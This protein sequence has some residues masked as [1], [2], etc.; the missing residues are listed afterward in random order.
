[1]AIQKART[2]LGSALDFL[3]T[4]RVPATYFAASVLLVIIGAYLTRHSDGTPSTKWMSIYRVEDI[5]NVREALEFYSNLRVPIPIPTSLLEIVSHLVS[6]NTL[7]VGRSVYRVSIVIA[8]WLALMMC[9]PSLSR[10]AVVF[11]VSVLFL[12][13]TTIIHP[14]NP[15]VYD[16]IF[17]C[18]VLLSLLFLKAANRA[19]GVSAGST[20]AA[21][22]AG[23]FLSLAELTRPFFIF[24]LPIVILVALVRLRELSRRH[25]LVFLAPII[26]LSGTWHLYQFTRYGQLTWSNHSGFNLSRAWPMVEP[27]DLIP[28]VSP[29]IELGRWPNLNTAEHAEN[30]RRWQAALVQYVIENPIYSADHVMRKFTDFAGAPTG[31]WAHQPVHPALD[32]YRPTVLF[33][34]T[35]VGVGSVLLVLSFAGYRGKATKLLGAPENA[36][37][38]MTFLSVLILPVS[39]MGEEARLLIS[40]LP[41]LA[42]MQPARHTLAQPGRDPRWAYIPHALIGLGIVLVLLSASIDL[43]RLGSIDFGTRQS[44][45]IVGGTYLLVTGILELRKESGA[46]SH[47]LST[48]ASR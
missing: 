3:R 28:E 47:Q 45:A 21:L 32:L 20:A 48:S 11:P 13:S 22:A 19:R 26:L 25:L 46:V 6:P 44:I 17:P 8:Y 14:G 29:P 18:F 4:H 5:A 12:W 16:V 33:A 41:F 23:L 15:Q 42:L 39:E 31:I 35:V 2:V 30:S 43:V 9:Y 37:I 10:L 34:I 24:L 36:L 40:I 38:V 7:F 1:M 27:P